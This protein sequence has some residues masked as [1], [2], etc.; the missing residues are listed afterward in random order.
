M[1]AMPKFPAPVVQV[2]ATP[3]TVDIMAKLENMMTVMALKCNRL[4]VL[5]SVGI[6]ALAKVWGG[7]VPS[8][9]HEVSGRPPGS[10]RR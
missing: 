10:G 7:A 5:A 4:Q 6:S 9:Q 1:L 3:N 2:Q 8:A